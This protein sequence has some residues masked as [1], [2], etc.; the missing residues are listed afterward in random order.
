MPVSIS[1]MTI[2]I[3]IPEKY[4]EVKAGEKIYFETDVKW[5][6]NVGRK[7]LRIEYSA[8]DS[9]GNEVAYLKVLK[10]VETQVSFM[11]SM[12]IPEN[13]EPGMYKIFMRISDYQDLNKEVASSFTVKSNG[14][15]TQIYLFV[16]I[17]LLTVVIIFLVIE[18]FIKSNKNNNYN[19]AIKFPQPNPK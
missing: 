1:A 12:Q 8:K 18:T 9:V 5:P 7:D 19:P 13:I 6:E 4:T 15:S 10:A 11:D 17:G 2:T 16:I 14:D 3:G